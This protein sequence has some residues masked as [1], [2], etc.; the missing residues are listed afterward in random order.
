MEYGRIRRRRLLHSFTDGWESPDGSEVREDKIV[1]PF[2][3]KEVD[4]SA[5]LEISLI[6]LDNIPQLAPVSLAWRMNVDF[7]K[8]G[9]KFC[10]WDSSL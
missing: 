2:L 4:S 7:V 9:L 8:G 6:S 3:F 10:I 5:V 1:E